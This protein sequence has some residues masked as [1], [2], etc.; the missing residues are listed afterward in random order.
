MTY[1]S[2][3]ILADIIFSAYT[4]MVYMLFMPGD[5][6]SWSR[7]PYTNTVN[8]DIFALYIFSRFLND[9]ETM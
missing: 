2:D 7:T 4:S 3:N 8:V 6:D 9:H 1:I 5:M